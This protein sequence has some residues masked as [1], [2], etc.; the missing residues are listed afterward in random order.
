MSPFSNDE[1]PIMAAY[2]QGRNPDRKYY[3][4]LLLKS[5]PIAI[6]ATD[7]FLIIKFKLT[8]TFVNIIYEFISRQNK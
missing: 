4:E 2:T 1:I 8:T 6:F 3:L 7:A 5:H